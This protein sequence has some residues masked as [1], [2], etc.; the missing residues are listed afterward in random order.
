VR[1][2]TKA[3]LPLRVASGAVFVAFGAGKFVAHASEVASF[4]AY[5]LPGPEVFTIAIG[6]VELAGGLLLIAGVRLRPAALVLAGDMAGAIVV[7][8]IARGELIS[9]TLAPAQLTAMIVIVWSTGISMPRVR[10]P[11]GRRRAGR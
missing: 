11:H 7:S 1:V 2:V 4:K 5:G 10:S 9:L 3:S 8:G 6:V